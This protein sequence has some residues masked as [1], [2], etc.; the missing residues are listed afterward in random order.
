MATTESNRRSASIKSTM[1][2][3]ETIFHILYCAGGFKKNQ[4]DTLRLT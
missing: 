3:I 4:C 1:K 2:R